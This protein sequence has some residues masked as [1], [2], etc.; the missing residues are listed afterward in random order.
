MLRNEDVYS[1]KTKNIHRIEESSV[2]GFKEHVD[3]C[4]LTDVYLLQNTRIYSSAPK[5]LFVTL[6]LQIVFSRGPDSYESNV[7]RI[8]DCLYVMFEKAFSNQN[9]VNKY[10]YRLEVKCSSDIGKDVYRMPSYQS[11][12]LFITPYPSIFPLFFSISVTST[13][14]LYIN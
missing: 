9:L 10:F 2:C 5:K 11:I 13:R 1:I 8:L 12:W 14:Y 3:R 6:R 4:L 7:I